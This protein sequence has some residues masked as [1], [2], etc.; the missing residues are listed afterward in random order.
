MNSWYIDR[1]KNF[2][3]DTLLDCLKIFNVFSKGKDNVDVNELINLI[4]QHPELN[5][6]EGNINAALTRFRDHGLLRNNNIIGDSAVDYVEGRLSESELI[7]DLFLKR[8]ANKHDSVDIKPFVLLCKVFDIMIDMVQDIDDI[9]ITSYECKEYLCCVNDINEITYD[10]VEKII[11][12]RDYSLGSSIPSPR[13]IFDNNE[14]TKF[15]IWFN[16]LN[17]TPI[18]I[19]SEDARK[20]LKP[21]LKQK[22]FFKYISVNSDEFSV[23]PTRS[24][25]ELY[26]YYCSRNTGL[27]EILPNIVHDNIEYINN[28]DIKSIFEYLFGYKRNF[29]INY[30]NYF[31]FECFGI[32]FPFIALPGLAI[33]KVYMNNKKLGEYLYDYISNRVIYEDYVRKFNDN[34][35]YFNTT[36]SVRGAKMKE[37]FKNWLENNSFAKNTIQNYLSSISLTSNEAIEDGILDK[38]IYDFDD[39]EELKLIVEKLKQNERFKLR[40]EKYNHINTAAISNYLKFLENKDIDN[41]QV[42]LKKYKKEDFLKEVYLNDQEYDTLNN[43]LTKKKNIILEGAPGV[44]KT[45]MAKKLAYSRIGFEDDSKILMVQFHQS[46][47]YEDFVEGIRPKDSKFELVDGIFKEFCVRANKDKNNDYYCIIDE[48]NRGNI[49]KIFGELLMLIEKDKRGK[50]RLKL[51]YSGKEFSV[52]D[53]LYIIGMLNT[54]DRSLALIDYA[55]RR[56]FSFYKVKPAFNNE[57]FKKYIEEYMDTRFNKLIEE[58]KNLNLAISEDDSLGDSFE[59]G[60]SY[61]CNLNH[62]YEKELNDIIE[63]DIVPMLKEYWFDEKS[64][65]KEWEERLFGVINE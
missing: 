5:I 41:I 12:E 51:P 22:E 6:A 39:I 56:R 49:S 50:E 18:F 29:S 8:P 57:N 62:E 3:Y 60:H 35:F 31:K 2:I 24:K 21:N 52:P 37:E 28:E 23:T 17:N 43:L 53:N 27:N 61:F 54:A 13:I 36:F 63:Y 65:S 42:Q 4:K 38:S 26:N 1:S 40:K 25:D 44:G 7:I 59:I 10:Y 14:D 55:L 58:I 15:S 47:S 33:R 19:K 11:D 30:K 16:A 32:F 64:K 9:F 20:V 34:L 48:I 45:F 46:Y